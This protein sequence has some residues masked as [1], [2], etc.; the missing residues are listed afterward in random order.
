MEVSV[1]LLRKVI[2][3][4]T[5]ASD[6]GGLHETPAESLTEAYAGLTQ[7]GSR[8]VQESAN[9]HAYQWLTQTPW[10]GQMENRRLSGT[11]FRVDEGEV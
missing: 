5:E 11:S 2:E 7:V 8:E 10:G 1:A 9:Y 6:G 4:G 3:G